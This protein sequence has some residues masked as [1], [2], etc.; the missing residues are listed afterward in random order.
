[1]RFW[2]G[3][4][5]VIK[6]QQSD[7]ENHAL[8]DFLGQNGAKNVIGSVFFQRSFLTC[9]MPTQLMG[10]VCFLQRPSTALENVCWKGAL[11]MF[12]SM[13]MSS[14]FNGHV[15][16]L[17]G[18]SFSHVCPARDYHN[19]ADEI[20]EIR[21]PSWKSI[22]SGMWQENAPTVKDEVVAFS[23]VDARLN[24]LGKEAAEAV[25]QRDR[26][27]FAKDIANVGRLF[28]VVCKGERSRKTNR[29][30]HCKAQNSIGASL[31]SNWMAE[32]CQFRSGK[33]GELDAAVD[34]DR[35][36]A[37]IMIM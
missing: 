32:N 37:N 24:E 28:Q 34:K 3:S 4:S 7:L 30:L 5:F 33:Q 29:I 23:S 14:L 21:D 8:F 16:K 2:N 11:G 25:W 17:L 1:M 12:V 18:G 20:L 10:I 15:L 6:W 9:L 27:T 35:F 36:V 13:S 22:D 31:V 26:I 19:E